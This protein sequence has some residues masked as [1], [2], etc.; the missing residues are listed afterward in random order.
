M[1]KRPD[2]V[3]YN[4]TYDDSLN[5]SRLSVIH[6]GKRLLYQKNVVNYG[7]RTHPPQ[8]RSRRHSGRHMGLLCEDLIREDLPGGIYIGAHLMM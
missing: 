8:E 3:I 4:G 1:D 7:E 6:N 2:T 5:E